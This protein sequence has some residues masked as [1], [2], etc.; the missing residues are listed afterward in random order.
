MLLMRSMWACC[1]RLGTGK[2][3]SHEVRLATWRFVYEPMQNSGDKPR[4]EKREEI[5][6]RPES[7][8][9]PKGDAEVVTELTDIHHAGTHGVDP[10]LSDSEHDSDFH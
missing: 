1:T 10:R 9:Y 8:G 5:N 3:V 2:P 6:A 4:T 7:G